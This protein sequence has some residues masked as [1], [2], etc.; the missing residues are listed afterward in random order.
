MVAQGNSAINDNSTLFHISWISSLYFLLV[1][2]NH[3]VFK[4]DFVLIGVI[5]EIVTIP[6]FVAQF[7]IFMLSVMRWLRSG[8]MLKGYLF[9][10]FLFSLANSVVIVLSFM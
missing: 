9:W 2:L 7:V 6:L 3:Y 4:S 8:C 1:A 5:M 10:A